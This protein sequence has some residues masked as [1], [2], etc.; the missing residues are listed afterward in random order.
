MAGHTS[1]QSSRSNDPF[2]MYASP[3]GASFL[4]KAN[5]I[6]EDFPISKYILF[7]VIFS[8]EIVIVFV[9]GI[10]LIR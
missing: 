5:K 1:G 7:F 4:R 6:F 8:I 9:L 3:V 2:G 10:Y